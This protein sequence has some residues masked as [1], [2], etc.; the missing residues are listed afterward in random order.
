MNDAIFITPE[1]QEAAEI[2]LTVLREDGSSDPDLD[3]NLPKELLLRMYRTMVL[4]R[5]L[6]DRLFKLQ[7]QGRIG[8][9]L[10]CTGEEAAVIGSVATL[11]DEDW[12]FP[13]YRETGL[14][15]WRGVP[16]RKFLAQ[17]YGN[18]EDNVKG[19]QMPVHTSFREAR[20]MSISSPVGTQIPQ[21]VG[22]AWAAKIVGDPTVVL[23]YFG[24]GATSEGDF[25][26]ACNFAGVFKVPVIFFCRNNQYAISVPLKRQTAAR[27]IAVKAV[28]YGLEGIRVDGNDVLAVYVATK[29]AVE[30]ARADGGPTLI[31]ALTYR[32]GAHSTSDDPRR[33]RS[34]EE[35]QQ[36]H[37][38]DPI[39]RF[40]RYL[41]W[42]GYWSE[43]QQ[44]SLAEEVRDLINRTVEDVEKI[45][46]PPVESLFDDV[47]ARIP[48][49]LQEQ[50][51]AY[52]AYLKEAD[53]WRS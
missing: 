47:Y 18:A 44:E 32:V 22:F 50:K 12:V 7:R 20:I 24:D 1:V 28:A 49:H 3:P 19:R 41:E 15:L 42:R 40:R 27:S 25:H 34:D 46:P 9:Y 31:E 30:K 21:A 6:D 16:L 38:K 36:W 10:T 35:V 37:T 48:R 39:E 5:E 23:V 29:R 52:L 11:N 45:P 8:F 2:P 51:E 14:P 13:S 17:Q 33:Y 43:L 26:V 4:N 53:R